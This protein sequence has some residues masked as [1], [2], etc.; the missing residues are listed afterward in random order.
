M[1][2]DVGDRRRQTER[3]VARAQAARRRAEERQLDAA[4]SRQRLEQHEAET[5]RRLER[6]WAGTARFGV[7]RDAPPTTLIP[8]APDPTAPDPTGPDPAGPDPA[9]PDP[10]GPDPAGP[11]RA[12]TGPAGPDFGGSDPA[13]PGPAEPGPA[14]LHHALLGRALLGRAVLDRAVLGPARPDPG[15]LGALADSGLRVALALTGADMGNVQLLDRATGALTIVA[16]RGFQRP[17]LDFFAV[18]DDDGSVCGR[19][20]STGAPVAVPDVEQDASLAGTQASRVLLEAGVRAVCST[21]LL[22]RYGVPL[23]M[24]SVHRRGTHEWTHAD[25]LLLGLLSRHLARL[26]DP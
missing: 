23:G 2:P 3:L 10:A 19:A 12:A 1:D 5:R 21:P 17:F 9:G 16:G 25:H 20:L 14:S 6:Q 26:L 4:Q 24:L 18:V 15:D 8:A 11:D 22:D 7:P 13:G